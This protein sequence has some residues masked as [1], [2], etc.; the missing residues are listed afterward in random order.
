MPTGENHD[1]LPDHHHQHLLR[2]RR[3][4]IWRWPAPVPEGIGIGTLRLPSHNLPPLVFRRYQAEDIGSFPR[5]LPEPLAPLGRDGQHNDPVGI[6]LP[7]CE[8]EQTGACLVH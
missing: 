6:F 7:E 8:F 5:C 3:G 4:H 1:G 2:G